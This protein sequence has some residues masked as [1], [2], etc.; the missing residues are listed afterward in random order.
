MATNKENSLISQIIR[1]KHINSVK[2]LLNLNED[3][4][5]KECTEEDVNRLTKRKSHF[6]LIILSLV[7]CGIEF[8]YAAETGIYKFYILKK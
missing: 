8:C 2:L 4:S 7:V 3:F 6:E 1:S 5:I